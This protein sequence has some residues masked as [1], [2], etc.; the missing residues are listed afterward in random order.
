MSV[1]VWGLLRKSQEDDETI[2]EACDR[3]V[4]NHNDDPDAHL[5]DG[6][7]LTSHRAMEIIDHVVG[8]VVADKFSHS[9][10]ISSSSFESLDNW[11][12]GGS[13]ELRG[14]PGCSLYIESGAVAESYIRSVLMSYPEWF[15]VTKNMLLQFNA[16]FDVSTN[17][18]AVAMI[19]VYGSMTT[20]QGFGFYFE[21]GVTK[22]FVGK[23]GTLTLSSAI[24]NDETKLHTYR[25]QL[26]VELGK[27]EFYIDGVQVASINLPSGI[28]S[29]EPYL[30][31]RLKT[32]GTIDGYMYIKQ[33][34]I[35]R[36]T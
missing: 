4:G 3:I 29:Y 28:S 9:E 34:D 25:A 32:N 26:N 36:E 1:D 12:T 21:N 30:E 27:F 18:K 17:Y 14:W 33:V 5:A 19:G 22:A 35:A 8:S 16:Y 15:N 6:Q 13:A 24:T 20:M 2:E 11:E 10:I 31:F 7:S 23:S